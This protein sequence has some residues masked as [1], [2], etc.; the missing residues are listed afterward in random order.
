RLGRGTKT[1]GTAL[2][3]T[4]LA[5]GTGAGTEFAASL[6]LAARLEFTALSVAL[7]ASAKTGGRLGVAFSA[8]VATLRT[9]AERTGGTIAG[10]TSGMLVTATPAA[11][12][13]LEIT[14]RAA[15]TRLKFAA[16]VELATSL[17]FTTGHE[18][19]TGLKFTAGF[20]IATG[21]ELTARLEVAA[22]LKF[23]V[24]AAI[25]GLEVTA[26]PA[27]FGTGA[28][29]AAT[30]FTER[31]IATVTARALAEWLAATAGA[32]GKGTRR[33]L[34]LQAGDGFRRDG[35]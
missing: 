2:C 17:E 11:F 27:A 15:R 33:T 12:A 14:T 3:A 32:T 6:K 22:R 18:V 9:V 23:T 5:F 4:E 25:A 24:G 35:L 26:T 19:A 8:P 10:R 20:E 31:A 16:W 30:A 29:I 13:G 34:G 21:L 7:R 28:T 1:A